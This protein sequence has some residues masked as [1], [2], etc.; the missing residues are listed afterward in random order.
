M[1]LKL[2]ERIAEMLR[3]V[4]HRRDVA[5]ILSGGGARGWAHI[6]A[7]ESLE[8][9]GYRIRAIAGT[10]MGAL[11]GGVYAAGGMAQ[12]KQQA[13]QLTRRQML[14]LFNLSPG[15]DHIS[16]G[17]G[18]TDLLQ[19]IVGDVQIN[20]LRI[21][22]CCSASDLVSGK[23]FVFTEGTLVTAIRASI[24][25]PGVFSPV[26]DGQHIFVDG[27]VHNT[28]PLNRVNRSGDDLLVAMNV[29][30]PDTEPQHRMLSAQHSSEKADASFWAR[31]PFMHANLSANHMSLL[32]RV[33]RLS[34][35]NNTM[36]ALKLTPPDIY[37]EMPMSSFGLLDF[38]KAKQII[39]RGR[40]EMDKAIEAWQQQEETE[41]HFL[42]RLGKRITSSR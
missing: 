33:A 28:L 15:L 17:Q 25:I 42:Q 30:A 16:N 37:A 12:L 23:E 4:N 29:S 40:Q 19:R 27:S 2:K 7:I 20:D 35:Q 24:T 21:P 36:M 5:L 31:L 9:H 39:A 41:R 13:L 8:T 22:F 38:D 18:V 14:H 32:L 6:G 26:N 3:N 10:S 11:V 34:I 1:I